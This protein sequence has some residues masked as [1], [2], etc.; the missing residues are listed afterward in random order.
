MPE[1]A[2]VAAVASKVN[3]R[4]EF[5]KKIDET[6]N[7][8]NF[9]EVADRIASD[10][11]FGKY[12]LVV[13][14]KTEEAH[15]FATTLLILSATSSIPLMVPEVVITRDEVVF[16]ASIGHAYEIITEVP[17]DKYSFDGKG[18]LERE[19]LKSMMDSF[20]FDEPQITAI[21]VSSNNPD[22]FLLTGSFLPDTWRIFERLG[23]CSTASRFGFSD[24]D[25]LVPGFCYIF[26]GGLNMLAS[27]E[28]E[29]SVLT[30]KIIED[31]GR[32]PKRQESDDASS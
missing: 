10:T 29:E 18:Q 27:I 19:K 6:I 11:L 13:S 7:H 15:E 28:D 32:L 14:D 24:H 16:T 26:D 5:S 9:Q 21:D 30:Q 23:I 22:I 25:T 4:E 12:R 2:I 17:E 31:L 1:L 20:S 3:N 8:Q